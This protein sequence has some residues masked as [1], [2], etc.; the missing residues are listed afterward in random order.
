MIFEVCFGIFFIFYFAVWH[1]LSDS[2]A[3]SCHVVD[4]IL[5]MKILCDNS[6]KLK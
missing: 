3:I 4:A 1:I 2:W 6:I 5:F